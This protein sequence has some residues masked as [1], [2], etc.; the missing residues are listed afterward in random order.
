LINKLVIEN[1]KHRPVRTALSMLAIGI[2]VTMMLTLVGVSYGLLEDSARRARGVGADIWVRPKGS[3]VISLSGFSMPEKFVQFLEKQ[4]HVS[5]AVGT[6][7]YPLQGVTTITG[8]DLDKFNRMSGGFKYLEG[9]PFK[10][11]NDLLISQFYAQQ[12]NLHVGDIVTLLDRRWRVCGI[13]EEGKLARLVIP[14]STLQDLTSNT[15]KVSQIFVKLDNPANTPSVVA[16]LKR[17][18]EGFPIYAMEELTSL[19]SVNNVPGLKTFIA[20]IIGLSVVVGFLVV[21]LSM[22]TSVLERTREIGILKALGASPGLVLNILFRETFVLA[23]AGSILG[24]ILTYGSRFLIMT[25]AASTLTQKIVPD[26]WPIAGG[27]AL[28][29]ALL[30]AFYPGL[31][32]ARQDP[33]EALSYE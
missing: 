19:I 28:L 23:V 13:V 7:V 21:F 14:I 17:K 31:R 18:M 32:A 27:I 24:I 25:F 12:N 15:G 11:P 22:Y 10:G 29:G 1:L 2:E 6:L 3:S 8:I 9:G 16:D 20:V 4:P 30:G 33:I 26:W 5:I